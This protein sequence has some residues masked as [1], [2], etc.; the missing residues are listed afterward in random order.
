M[1]FPQDFDRSMVDLNTSHSAYSNLTKSPWS[2]NL[3][4]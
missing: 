1:K 3:I 4:T 2:E